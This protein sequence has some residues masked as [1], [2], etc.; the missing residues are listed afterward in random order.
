[1]RPTSWYQVYVLSALL[2]VLAGYL[3]ALV[4][5]P[6]LLP[7]LF[8]IGGLTEPKTILFLG[9]DVVYNEKGGNKRAEKTAFNGRTDTIMLARL[10]PYSNSLDVLSIPRDTQANI[11]GYGVQKINAANVLGGPELTLRTV[12]SLLDLPV[13]NYLILNVHGLMEMINELGGITVE[14]PKPMH[15][16][17]WTAKLLIDL[18]PG[19]HTL[20]GNQA[21]GFVRFRH[22]ALGDIGRVQRQEIFIR[23]LLERATKPDAWLHIPRLISIAQDY[24]NTNMSMSFILKIA[25]FMRGIP[26]ENRHMVMLPG[27]F[28]GTGDW[29]AEP[30]DIHKIV[31][32]F[33][34]STFVSLERREIKLVIINTSSSPNLASQVARYLRTRGYTW[35]QIKRAESASLPGQH[36]RVIAQRANPE[37]ANQ[38][39]ADLNQTG[40][41]VY[42]S[43]GD[44]E[45]TVTVFAGDDLVRVVASEGDK[46]KIRRRQRTSGRSSRAL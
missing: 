18:S 30:D 32:K 26:K 25:N 22:D 28:S 29:V 40:E 24:I 5:S 33:L 14:I 31:N 3:F 17:D 12:S 37:D 7:P 45:S 36:T 8:R 20:T 44:I 23:A 27:H 43:V 16:M 11:P 21:M 39:L 46:P 13:D 19:F 41:L 2:G 38:V 42:A 35:V 15:Y 4:F 10:D 34:G 1:M 6:S 9:T